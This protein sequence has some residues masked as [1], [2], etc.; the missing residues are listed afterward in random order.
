MVPSATCAAFHVFKDPELLARVRNVA[1]KHCP[2]GGDSSR[3]AAAQSEIKAL[4]ADPLLLSVY[5]ETLRLYIKVHAAFSSPHE[6]ITLGQWVLPKGG[7][8][9]ISSEPAHMDADFWNTQDGKHPLQSFW[10]DRFV[11]DPSDPSSGPIIPELRESMSFGKDATSVPKT[12]PYFSTEGC[13]GAWLPY[14]GMYNFDSS[15]PNFNV[16]VKLGIC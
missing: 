2:S 3:A 5:A 9:L 10:A 12:E 8:A 6:D 15:F 13:E 7:I 1:D 11:I 14:G 16:L 4:A